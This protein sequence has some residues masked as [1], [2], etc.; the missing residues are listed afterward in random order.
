VLGGG[1]DFDFLSGHTL[2]GRRWQRYGKVQAVINHDRETMRKPS[3][4]TWTS[5]R[6]VADEQTRENARRAIDARRE[7]PRRQRVVAYL[8]LV[9]DWPQVEIAALLGITPGAIGK[10]M[11]DARGALQAQRIFST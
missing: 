4:V 5:M 8:H 11:S 2:A 7:L 9:E 3:R 1:K 6:T 10:H